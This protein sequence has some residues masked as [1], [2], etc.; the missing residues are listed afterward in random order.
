MCAS[1]VAICNGQRSPILQKQQN[2]L[3]SVHPFQ[4]WWFSRH[5]RKDCWS[6][7]AKAVRLVAR[8]GRQAGW[9]RAANRRR[10]KLEQTKATN[11]L[12]KTITCPCQDPEHLPA[13][14]VQA[15]SLFIPTHETLQSAMMAYAAVE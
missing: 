2:R 9:E 4:A 5:G 12:Y 3:P 15:A 11:A 8:H 14:A 13:T 7:D 10:D 6:V 1:A